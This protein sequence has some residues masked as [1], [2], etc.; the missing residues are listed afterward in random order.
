[1]R[2]ILLLFLFLNTWLSVALSK[3]FYL[4]GTHTT[5][6]EITNNHG[7]VHLSNYTT[8][9]YS[10]EVNFISNNKMQVISKVNLNKLILNDKYPLL[11]PFKNFNLIPYLQQSE[12]YGN[13]NSKIKNLVIK[14]TKNKSYLYEVVTHIL[15]Y[16]GDNITYVNNFDKPTEALSVLTSKEGN[17]EGFTNLAVALLRNAGIPS[18]AVTTYAFSKNNSYLHSIVEVY[19]PSSGWIAYDPQGYLNFIDSNNIYLYSEINDEGKIFYWQKSRKGKLKLIKGNSYY[20]QLNDFFTSKNTKIKIINDENNLY[21]IEVENKGKKNY[22]SPLTKNNIKYATVVG[23]VKDVWGNTLSYNNNQA[24]VFL[25]NNLK[26]IGYRVQDNGYFSITNIKS[27]AITLSAK[28]KDLTQSNKQKIFLSKGNIYFL[29]FVLV[30]GANIKGKLILQNNKT[31]NNYLVGVSQEENLA[32]KP[33][34]INKNGNF[35]I[36]NISAGDYYILV[37]ERKSKKLLSKQKIYL[38]SGITESI[39]LVVPK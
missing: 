28:A 2:N 16:V 1:M 20:A 8:P 18:R 13:K 19:F 12:H 29:D 22:F 35:F 11:L 21:A 24:V 4:Q 14:L 25:W 10:Q 23:K 32:F 39:E 31:Y 5:I 33:Y 26:G 36:D 6:F 7:I 17:C 9:T 27:S 34:K 38:K 3:T 15:T 30:P 37:V